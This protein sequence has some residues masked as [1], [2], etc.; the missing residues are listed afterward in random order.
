MESKERIES[1]T[2]L[3]KGYSLIDAKFAMIYTTL[4]TLQE[5][6]KEQPD[7]MVD[8]RMYVSDVY[9]LISLF[10]DKR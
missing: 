4:V 9:F 7:F 3:G 6:L 5:K 10:K 8:G 2:I 1:E